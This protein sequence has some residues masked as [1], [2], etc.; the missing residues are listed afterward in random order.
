LCLGFRG[1]KV[2]EQI[3]IAISLILALLFNCGIFGFGM[4][5]FT[6]NKVIVEETIEIEEDKLDSFRRRK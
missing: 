5:N 1:I 4:A 3:P 6:D 2:E